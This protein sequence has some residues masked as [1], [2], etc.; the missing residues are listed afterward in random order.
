MEYELLQLIFSH[1]WIE[2]SVLWEFSC[3]LDRLSPG[4]S[5]KSLSSC[6]ISNT[7]YGF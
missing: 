6:T 1:G 3:A 7:P 2:F 5:V 4:K